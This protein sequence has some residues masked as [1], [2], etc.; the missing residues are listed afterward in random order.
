MAVY[1][2]LHSDP[3]PGISPVDYY[4]ESEVRRMSYSQYQYRSLF[5]DMPSPLFPIQRPKPAPVPVDVRI[6]D[7]I[8]V[9]ATGK[10]TKLAYNS[11][12]RYDSGVVHLDNGAAVD[13]NGVAEGKLQLKVV[14][15]TKPVRG[16]VIDA[17]RLRETMWKRGTIIRGDY[18]EQILVLQGDGT[19]FNTSAGMTTK[20]S[21]LGGKWKLLFDPAAKA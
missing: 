21:L 5:A 3:Y 8:T 14:G 4:I 18:S 16:D 17:L 11:A 13:L 6:G 1:A 20:F 19:W 10:V 2:R 15:R 9:T 12:G 7:T